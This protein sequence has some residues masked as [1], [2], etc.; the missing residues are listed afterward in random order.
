MRATSYG[1]FLEMLGEPLGWDDSFN[2]N[3]LKQLEYLEQVSIPKY[4]EG[5]DF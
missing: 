5:M 1:K 3:Y 2:F 4:N